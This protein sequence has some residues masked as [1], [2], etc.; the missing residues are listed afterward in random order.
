MTLLFADGCDLYATIAGAQRAGWSTGTGT[1]I[2]TTLGRFGGGSLTGNQ[3]DQGFLINI[4]KLAASD[5]VI[6]QWAYT[7]LSGSIAMSDD[8]LLEIREGSTNSGG[9][10]TTVVGGIRSESLSGEIIDAPGC[11]RANGWNYIE[12][13][14]FIHNTTGQI[15][16]KMNGEQ[17]LQTPATIDTLH[18]T[19]PD[20]VRFMGDNINWRI[21]DIIIMDGSGDSMN[22][23]IGDTRITTLLPDSDQLEQWIQSESGPT[24]ELVDDPLGA[25]EDDTTYIESSTN[26]DETRCG[27]E[28]LPANTDVVH[29]VVSTY[30]AK[31][32]DA[33]P[34]TIRGLINSNSVEQIGA[35]LVQTAAYQLVRDFYDDD[36]GTGSP[37]T[38]WTEAA[39]NALEMGVE[40]VS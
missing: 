34:R 1:G 28:D 3:D 33:G 36:P 11:V 31:M 21:D 22:D 25:D 9:M 26:T 32:T 35:D 10:R 37:Q 5:T 39:V 15:T 2:G 19:G 20:N 13:K 23:F 18:S 16:I 17:V 7:P 4:P 38:A 30:A 40:V 6:V 8:R 27:F 24:Y 14:M 12:F 29:A